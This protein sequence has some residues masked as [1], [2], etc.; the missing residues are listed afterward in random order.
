MA[1]NIRGLFIGI[2]GTGDEILARLKD[3]VFATVGRIP[4]GLQ[5][6]LID[7]EAD[8]YRK[9]R[10]AKLGG[11]GSATAIDRNEYLQLKDDP[12]GTFSDYTRKVARDPKSVAEIARWYRADLFEENLPSADFNL[13]RG[14]GQHRQFSR[15][16]MYLNKQRVVGMLRYALEQCG[17]GE[18]E[19][20]I[21]IIGSV[22]GGTGAGLYM[23]LAL[24]ARLVSEEMHMSRR[25]IGAA[26]L[27][28]VYKDVTIDGARA[29]AVIRELERFQAPVETEYRG[30]LSEHQDG[31]RF[32]VEY[33]SGTQVNL[34]DK[35]FDNL[36]FYNRECKDN[37]D[38]MN[39]FSEIADG[40]NLLLDHTAGN[41]IFREWINAKEGAATSFNSH[42]IFLPIRLY[43]RQFV[44]D[45]A[46]DV[47]NGL[48]PRD[49]DG[50]LLAGS[51]DDRRRDADQIL[52]DELFS[53]FRTLH[54]AVTERERTD[55]SD[56]M[57]PAFI[58]ND[59]LGF[60]N[61]LGVF[62]EPIGE[63]RERAAQRLYAEVFA[64]VLTA[65]DLKESFDDSRA[66]VLAE[67]EQRRRDYDGDGLGSFRASLSAVKPLIEDRVRES[68]DESINKY[69]GRQRAAEQA[70]GRTN[71]VLFELTNAFADLRKG[72]EQIVAN[73]RSELES[74]RGEEKDA[75]VALSEL[76]KSLFGWKG[77]L[78]DAEEQYI[79]A[80]DLVSQWLQREELVA[81]LRQLIQV[82]E[83]HLASWREGLQGWQKAILEVVTRASDENSEIAQRLDRQTKIRSASIGMSNTVDMD[84]YRDELRGRCLINPDSGRSFV[85]DLMVSL[86]WKPGQRPEDIVLEGWPGRGTLEARDFPGV[87]VDLFR[88]HVA[89]RVREFEGMGRYLKWIRDDRRQPL[90]NI[91]DR[92][93]S[94]T[95]NFLDQRQTSDTRKLLLLHGDAWNRERDGDNAFDTIYNAMAGGHDMANKIQH[96]LEQ[97]GV[98]LFE[99][100][101]VLA[102]L[103]SD[104]A[105]PY[106]EIAAF[107]RMRRD[108]LAVRDED[109]PEWR[110]E[111]YHLFRCDQ[112]AWRIEHKLVVETRDT[113][114]P[115]I[116]GNLCRLL[117]DPKSVELFVKS[118]ASGVIRAQPVG[119][120][121]T[122][123]VCGPV[124]E[125]D[126]KRLIFL[127]D[128]N[129]DK[130]PRDLLRALVT[131]TMDGNDRRR[132]T[133]GPID[134]RRVQGWIEE[135]LVGQGTTLEDAAESFR[136]DHPELFET[137][138]SEAPTGAE[139]GKDAFLSLVLNHYM[140]P[141]HGA[142]G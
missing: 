70:L 13:Q 109:H 121:G 39:Y 110:A 27:P 1:E 25:I 81:Y 82:A 129:D 77:V 33:D 128:P 100:R 41:Q 117:D 42:R 45:A 49:S 92:L 125:D 136:A 35:L 69:L 133:R 20:P 18:G 96:N 30:R 71:R 122:V 46:M 21:W 26:V 72:L 22:A 11:D 62:R 19:L 64:E 93:S 32:S 91:S 54:A 118:L 94:V 52:E 142:R 6:R 50:V 135:T 57:T 12:P 73:D 95:R 34:T 61:P 104:N 3:K 44:L 113:H 134:A 38:R 80:A 37:E 106:Q 17:G 78:A 108:Y 4:P 103:M 107:E 31:I 58:V 130:D 67:V 7:T 74:A 55:L 24:L 2:G 97:D 127:N 139:I 68:I 114:F 85:D 66:R 119:L 36:V 132:R 79:S 87:L 8:D 131:F 48:L 86:T 137:R 60:A 98:I 43:E 89:K 56:Q 140:R 47:A 116:P 123:W 124:G 111:T 23:D 40:L 112:E 5:F 15:M 75:R 99:D 59:M 105:I 28:D 29:Y 83:T 90:S 16:G 88:G 10:G 76:E 126:P 63:A 14:A 115:E 141:T 9:S 65:R 101:N 53:V 51:D 84:G 138:L 120:G 102:V